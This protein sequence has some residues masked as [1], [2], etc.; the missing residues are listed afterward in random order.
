MTPP[1]VS[2]I[3]PVY[4]AQNTLAQCVQSVRE[5]TFDNWELLL[6]DD[7]STDESPA[8]CENFARSDERIRVFH[9]LRNMGVSEARNRGLHEAKGKWIAFLDADD[10]FVPETL[11]TLLNLCVSVNPSA[12]T[13]A[14]HSV[15]PSAYAPVV[16]P[17]AHGSVNPSA[18][19]Q[20]DT[21]GCAHWNVIPGGRENVEML[22]PEGVYFPDALR[23]QIILPLFGDRLSV[24]I[25]NGYIWRYL[26][27]AQIIREHHIVF[28]GAY[29]EDDLFLLEY[30]CHAQ[31]LAVT[32]RPLY[33]YFFNPSSATR[34]Y[35]RDVMEVLER[36]M[37]R[38]EILAERC[39]LTE[40]CPDW[41][42][43]A[44][45]SNLIIAVANEYAHGNDKTMRERQKT[46]KELCERPEMQR[47]LK[48]WDTSGMG[49]SKRI[50]A[51]LLRGRHFTLL[52]LLYRLKNRL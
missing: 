12:Y 33:R 14:N 13:P 6:I 4:Q 47:A 36:N 35:M 20:P 8:M 15:N 28:E 24:P 10:Q 34:R 40:L 51:D 52:T 22:L 38:R 21:A 2:V 17:S 42:I 27:S 5:Q 19:C 43:H 32:Q 44:D 39:G 29:L 50:V 48:D 23:E 11:Q 30:F 7:A 31:C 26:F 25:F 1:L 45:R 18:P 3:V 9:Q 49:K 37:E 46:V 16:N 41:R